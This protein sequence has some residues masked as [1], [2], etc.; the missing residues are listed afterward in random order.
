MMNYEIFKEV[1]AEKILSYMPEKYQNM[2][3]EIHPVNKVNKEMDGL[4]LKSEEPGTSIAPTIYVNHLY[5]RYVAT[6]DLI[7]E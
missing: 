6:E 7:M 2:E 3:V 4:T 1:V 5:D